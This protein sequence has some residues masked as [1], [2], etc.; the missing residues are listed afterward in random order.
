MIS[1][2][3]YGIIGMLEHFIPPMN[4]LKCLIYNGGVFVDSEGLSVLRDWFR[5]A[6]L[7]LPPDSTSQTHGFTSG[8]K[9]FI[10]GLVSFLSV[11]SRSSLT[12]YYNCIKNSMLC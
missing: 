12:V 2:Y 8:W 6:F 10:L 3:K 4:A 1:E 9:A 11:A 5:D 7:M